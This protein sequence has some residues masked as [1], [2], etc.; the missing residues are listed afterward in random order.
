M[1]G[2]LVGLLLIGFL[3][4]SLLSLRPGGLRNQLRNVGRRLKLALILAGIYLLA[5]AGLRVAF[6]DDQRSLWGT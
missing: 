3:T 2:F 6:G 4:I 1:R 5:S